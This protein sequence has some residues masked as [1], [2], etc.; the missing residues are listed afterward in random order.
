[1]SLVFPLYFNCDRIY[2][3]HAG[4]ST[5]HS[6]PKILSLTDE[7]RYCGKKM[8]A[9]YFGGVSAA[10]HLEPYATHMRYIS[11]RI[12]KAENIQVIKPESV[13]AVH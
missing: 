11:P 8:P 4:P 12:S 9:V 3:N 7:L 10:S 1:M 6:Y 2:I 13:G 5:R